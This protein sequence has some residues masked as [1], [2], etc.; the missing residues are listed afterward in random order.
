MR[1][2]GYVE[3]FLALAQDRVGGAFHIAAAAELRG[4]VDHAAFTAALEVLH[5]RHPL[6]GATVHE[7]VDGPEAGSWRFADEVPFS[8]VP[9]RFGTG[10]VDDDG[11]AAALGSDLDDRFAQGGPLWK[12]DLLEV[13]GTDRAL[14]SLSMHHVIGD[15]MSVWTLLGH[16]VDVYGELVAGGT[17]ERERRPVQPPV[18]HLL[19][20]VDAAV[21][22]WEGTGDVPPP[23]TFAPVPF[24]DR[25]TQVVIRDLEAPLVAAL[26]AGAHRRG[27]TVNA[28]LVSAIV[29]AS[30]LLPGHQVD[31]QL[32][33][34]T[35]VR[36]RVVPPVPD[37]AVGALFRD[38]FVAFDEPALAG[39][40]WDGARLLE[41]RYLDGAAAQLAWT[42]DVTPAQLHADVDP[43]LDPT[44]DW[45]ALP[46]AVTNLGR[47]AAGP[48]DA[49][50]AV[51]SLYANV[52][53][54][55]ANIGVVL[56]VATVRDRM[57]LTFS[58]TE[59]LLG[60]ADTEALADQV[61]TLIEAAAGS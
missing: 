53:Q 18:E 48:E 22:P 14:L 43:F 38:V 19:P 10:A 4:P 55:T 36:P 29:R 23:W 11:V 61:V 20:R 57:H 24:A 42:P 13:P 47:L 8:A 33:V 39:D 41:Q 26:H 15:G 12:V 28:A 17:P 5:R 3:S 51:E 25:A 31:G 45:Y 2:L 1:A 35:N 52:S 30:S 59:P 46:M 44:R 27:T 6:L 50:L 56:A 54:R 9:V 16:L 37:D 21:N 40:L 58:H 34:P 60:V 32:S 7:V 49:P